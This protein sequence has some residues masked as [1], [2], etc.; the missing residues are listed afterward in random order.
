MSQIYGNGTSTSTNGTNVR[1]DALIEKG[2]RTAKKDIIFEQLCDSRTLPMNHGKT[3]K[4]HKTLYILDDANDNGQGL[5]SSAI[6]G[7]T[8]GSSTGVLSG[9]LYGGSRSV[10]DVTNGLPL[11]TETS[12]RANRVGI[13]RITK[14]GTLTRMGAFLEYTDEVDKFSD[15]KM[16]TQYYEKM[17]ELAAEL[18]DDYLQKELLGACGIEYYGGVATSLLTVSGSDDTNTVASDL[19]YETILDTEDML[20]ANYAKM[21]TSIIDGSRNVGTVPVNASYFAYCGRD[22]VRSLNG[23]KDD[24]EQKAFV[25]ARMYAAAGNLAKNEVG[26]VHSTRFIQAQRMMRFDGCGSEVGANPTGNYKSTALDAAGAA[27][28][29]QSAAGTFYDGLPLIYVTK[30]AFATVGLQGNKKINF[31]SKKPGTATYEDPHGLQG[32]YSFNFFAGSISLEPEKMA[33]I[34]FATKF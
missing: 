1:V 26:A 20:E 34:V 29:G 6:A 17:G 8:D 15:A 27:A 3:L 22:S 13:T 7:Q 24:F 4:V 18:Y 21:N 33:R 19:A 11:I 14:E 9:N 12:G 23:L 28:R 5:G 25:P 16:E 31:L 30:G 10:V 32:I 2:I